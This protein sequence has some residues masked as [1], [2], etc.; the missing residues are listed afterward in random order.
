MECY[1]D[2]GDKREEPEI[3]EWGWGSM[4]AEIPPSNQITPPTSKTQLLPGEL[5]PRRI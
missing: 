4:W 5:D 1:Q 3:R 2:A